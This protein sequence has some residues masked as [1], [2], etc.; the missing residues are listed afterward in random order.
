MM[1]T[2]EPKYLLGCER[3]VRTSY[4]HSYYSFLS[5]LDD[6]NAQQ[7]KTNKYGITTNMHRIEENG[8]VQLIRISTKSAYYIDDGC[9]SAVE[10]Y[11]W[12]NGSRDN[13]N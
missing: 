3:M 6:K 11:Q 8:A 13:V 10:R 1:N 4:N 5:F 12:R 7:D 2:R 9:K